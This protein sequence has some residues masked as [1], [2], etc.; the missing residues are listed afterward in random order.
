MTSTVVIADDDV[1][2]RALVRIS[3]VRAGLNV[4]AE[5]GNGDEALSAIRLLVPELAIL[6]VSMPGLSGLEVC[7]LVRADSALD[8]V[9]VLLVS[10][11]AD[12]TS[13]AAGMRAGAADYL[14]KPFSPR[15]L[16]SRLSAHV[17]GTR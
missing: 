3:A 10:A 1:D 13:I 12:E 15:E 7:R 8:G 5:A 6:D 9:Q 2:I 14:S 16:A 11:A 4:V 17:G